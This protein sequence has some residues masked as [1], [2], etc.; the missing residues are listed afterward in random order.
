MHDDSER[1]RRAAAPAAPT[2]AP[3]DSQ[4]ATVSEYVIIHGS[5]GDHALLRTFLGAVAYTAGARRVVD[6]A[7]DPAAL[8]ADVIAN[9]ERFAAV[10]DMLKMMADAAANHHLSDFFKV[11]TLSA[12]LHAV[13]QLDFV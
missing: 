11:S 9:A 12:Q 8:A 1:R 7:A 2:A 4:L 3:L 13:A 5:H 10:R 6:A